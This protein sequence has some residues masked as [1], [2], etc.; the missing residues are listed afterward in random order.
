MLVQL[1]SPKMPH[2]ARPP[3]LLKKISEDSDTSDDEIPQSLNTVYR[4]MNHMKPVIGSWKDG[5]DSFEDYCI[6]GTGVVSNNA[7]HL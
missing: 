1:L 2:F 6:P 5:F 3:S 4:K 7:P